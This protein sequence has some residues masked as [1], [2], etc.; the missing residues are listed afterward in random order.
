MSKLILTEFLE[1]KPDASLLTEEERKKIEEGEEI[2][3][4]GVMQRAG[5]TN[6]NG[7][8]YPLPILQREVENYQKIVREGR[9]VGELDHPDSSVV[10]LKNASHLVTEIS[11]DGEDVVGKIKIL[12]TPAGKTAIGLLKGGVKLGISSRGL[13]STRQEGGNTIVQEDFQL[14][15]FDLVSE[16]STAGAFMLREGKEPNIF[17]KADKINRLL[18]DILSD[19]K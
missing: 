8:V 9:A 2:Y 19:E 11:M 12:D 15:C 7:R 16:P 1:F 6:G 4:A 10:E 3:L 17:T 14:V 13:G 5:A 18:N